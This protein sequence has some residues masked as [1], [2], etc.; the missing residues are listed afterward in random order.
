MLPQD[1]I[2]ILPV[3]HNIKKKYYEEKYNN[4]KEYINDE[5]NKK[6]IKKIKLFILLLY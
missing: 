3:N 4:L 6:Q 5:E 1:L 2:C